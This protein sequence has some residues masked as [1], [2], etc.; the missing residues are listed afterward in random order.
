MGTVL[1]NYCLR[2]LRDPD[3]KKEKWQEIRPETPKTEKLSWQACSCC[4]MPDF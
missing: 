1:Y 2:Y 3:G 4:F